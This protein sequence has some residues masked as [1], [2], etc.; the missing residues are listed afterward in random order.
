MESLCR[1]T[2][3]PNCSHLQMPWGCIINERD[4]LE[5]QQFRGI[6]LFFPLSVRH[7]KKHQDIPLYAFGIVSDYVKQQYSVRNW[8]HKK[9]LLD[10]MT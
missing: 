6:P 5:M 3:Y 10:Q 1:L 2:Q 9:C 7:Y 4:C 8:A